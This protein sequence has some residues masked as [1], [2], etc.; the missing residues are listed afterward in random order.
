[1]KTKSLKE[2]ERKKEEKTLVEKKDQK[3][4]FEADKPK[5]KQRFKS[6]AIKNE[7]DGLSINKIFMSI[8]ELRESFQTTK[9]LSKD[10]KSLEKSGFKIKPKLSKRI[11][12]QKKKVRK[13]KMFNIF[14]DLGLVKTEKEKKDIERQN[15]KKQQQ[16]ELC[17]NKECKSKQIEG[18]SGKE[19]KEVAKGMV[20]KECPKC[21]EGK[22]VLRKSIYGSFFACNQ[23]PKCKYTEKI[24]DGPSN[25][26]SVKNK[27]V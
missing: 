24:Q 25:E 20:E 12:E 16:K 17:I 7:A 14:H 18:E 13:E 15:Q 27:P 21:K 4:A 11:Q 23:Y 2:L 3:A 1:V 6:K 19:A 22:I 10:K 8:K 5:E 9:K 26:D